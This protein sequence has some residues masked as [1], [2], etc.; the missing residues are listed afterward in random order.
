MQFNLPLGAG[1]FEIPDEWWAFAEMQR[2]SPS[3]G[4]Y[5]PYKL[6]PAN[7]VVIVS[8]DE[9]EPPRRNPGT[10]LL[11]KFKLMPVLFAFQSP[12]C[13]LPA[14][15]VHSLADGPCRYTVHN[16]FH[17]YYGSIA[18]RYTH[19]PVIVCAPFVP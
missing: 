8:I 6:R 11:K 2:F 12:E 13:A 17:R 9:V 15:E 5:Y 3:P 14:I 7:D 16:G 18:A 19:L 10:A 1:S 4:G